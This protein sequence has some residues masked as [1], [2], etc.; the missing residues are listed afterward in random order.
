MLRPIFEEHDLALDPRAEPQLRA[1][2]KQPREHVRHKSQRLG[3]RCNTPRPPG[4]DAKLAVWCSVDLCRSPTGAAE[5]VVALRSPCNASGK[6]CTVSRGPAAAMGEQARA[7][8]RDFRAR[9]AGPRAHH[10]KLGIRIVNSFVQLDHDG[11]RVHCKK[12]HT[13]G[14]CVGTVGSSRRDGAPWP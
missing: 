10:H 8:A 12:W 13:Q 11:I 1:R 7:R 2:W 9:V 5:Q 6:P 4:V 3:A 14:V